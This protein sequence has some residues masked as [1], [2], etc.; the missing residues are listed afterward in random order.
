MPRY[1]YVG[2]TEYKHRLADPVRR[3]DGKVIVGRK[4]RNQLIRWADSGEL[5]VVP[6][7]TLRL[8]EKWQATQ[9]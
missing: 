2:N 5:C 3:P 6:A 4:P 8:Y 1:I 7:R 9:R